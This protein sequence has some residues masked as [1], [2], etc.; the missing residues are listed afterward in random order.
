MKNVFFVKPDQFETARNMERRLLTLPEES[1]ILFVG[2]SVLPD[3]DE[4]RTQP[5]YRVVIGCT[6]EREPDLMVAAAKHF[7]R[8]FVDDE[9]QLLVEGYRGIGRTSGNYS[10]TQ[11][12]SDPS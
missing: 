1:G 5:V 6:R 4:K 7:L 11:K 8:E 2:V 12:A 10:A 9:R 3:P